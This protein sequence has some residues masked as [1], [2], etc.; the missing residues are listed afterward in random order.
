MTRAATEAMGGLHDRMPVILNSDEQE[1]W[2]GGS[3]EV[4]SL[5]AGATLAHH[6]VAPFGLHDDGPELIERVSE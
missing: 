1:A 6:S 3:D 2:L 4:A 5:G